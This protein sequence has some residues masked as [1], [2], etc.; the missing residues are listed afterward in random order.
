MM[1]YMFMIMAGISIIKKNI[2]I[3]LAHYHQIPLSFMIIHMIQYGKINWFL[4]MEKQ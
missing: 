4:T 1:G 3:L 2:I